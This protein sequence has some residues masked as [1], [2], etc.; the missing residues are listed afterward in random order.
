[1]N[2]ERGWRLDCEAV[3]DLET[4]SRNRGKYRARQAGLEGRTFALQKK[5]Q[6]NSVST[7][8]ESLALDALS[9]FRALRTLDL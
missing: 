1:L 3:D 7:V 5:H 8:S 4:T 9:G 6:G 2:T